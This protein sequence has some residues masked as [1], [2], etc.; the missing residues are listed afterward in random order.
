MENA[1]EMMKN[2]FCMALT[3]RCAFLAADQVETILQ[4]LDQVAY[5]YAIDA[6]P[7]ELSV[8]SDG[9]P[10]L[11]KIYL[12]AKTIEGLADSTMYNKLLMLKM[13]FSEVMK[14]VTDIT[15]NDIRV[16]LYNYQKTRNV[17]N[18][19]L[20]KVR[21]ALAT[22]FKWLAAEGYIQRDPATTIKPLKVEKKQRQS[23]SQIELEYIRKACCTIR[24]RAIVEFL[25]S[26]GCRI[27]ELVHIKKSDVDFLTDEVHLFGKGRKHRTSY[28]NA[29]AHVVLQEYLAARKDDSEYLFVRIRRPVGRLSTDAVRSM[30]REISKRT[31]IT[32]PVSPHII[33]HTTA[34]QAVA[35]GMPIEEVRALLGHENVATTMIYVETSD[36]HVHN[37]HRKA[38]V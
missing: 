22:F 15:A 36:E 2:E 13:F 33:R 35:N 4:Q 6:K 11:A 38:V 34:T 9:L 30:L 27:S 28:L 7:T 24:E 3:E 10:E 18:I 8:P 19:S 5:N 37:S 14:P 21:M 29:K 32:K 20:D 31:S 16:Y 1:Y 25:Y 12:A 26:T 17:S 23:L